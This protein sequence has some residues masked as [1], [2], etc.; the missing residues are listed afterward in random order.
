MNG[1]HCSGALLT[2]QLVSKKQCSC[3]FPGINAAGLSSSVYQACTASRHEKAGFIGIDLV[4]V[5]GSKRD[6]TPQRQKYHHG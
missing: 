4:A 2:Y 1:I 3:T 5:V 6:T